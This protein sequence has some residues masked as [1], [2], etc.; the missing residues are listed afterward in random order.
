MIRT[1]H[2]CQQEACLIAVSALDDLVAQLVK[3][4][5]LQ[6]P[7]VFFD[8]IADE[9]TPLVEQQMA[10]C[11]DHP[12]FAATLR[13]GDHRLVLA[14]WMR[15]WVRPGLAARFAQ[16][17]PHLPPLD[18]RLPMLSAPLPVPVVAAVPALPALHAAPVVVSLPKARP[19]TPGLA[20][21]A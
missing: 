12:Q 20:V 7:A 17:L 9:A 21:P 3:A 19:R 6:L 14:S 2:L 16:L 11:F 1:R 4:C 5:H 18:G 15:H 10:D 13:Q 8:W